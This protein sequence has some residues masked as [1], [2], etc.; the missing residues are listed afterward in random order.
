MSHS[1]SGPGCSQS[2][3]E[4]SPGVDLSEA[5]FW[6]LTREDE[7]SDRE[8]LGTHETL[9][10]CSDECVTEFINGKTQA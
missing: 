8:V 4:N 6:Q 9:Y 1:C 7:D 10:F 5:P 3:Q 2:L